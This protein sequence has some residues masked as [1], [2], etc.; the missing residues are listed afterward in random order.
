MVHA[1]MVRCVSRALREGSRA[2]TPVQ[3]NR[4]QNMLEYDTY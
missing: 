2:T 3:Y 4:E 1:R